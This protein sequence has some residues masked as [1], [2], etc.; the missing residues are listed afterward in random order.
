MEE[1]DIF[2]MESELEG[3]AASLGGALKVDENSLGEHPRFSHQYKNAAKAS[4]QQV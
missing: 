4:E 2:R 1:E 3:L